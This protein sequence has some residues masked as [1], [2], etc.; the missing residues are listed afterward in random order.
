MIARVFGTRCLMAR[1]LVQRGVRFI[2]LSAV[3]HTTCQLGHGDLEVN[4]NKHAGN[5][6]LPIAALLADLKQ[7]GMLDETLVVWGGSSV[8][9]RQQ[10]TPKGQV[11]TTIPMV[12]PCGWLEAASKEESVTVPPMNLVLVQWRILCMSRICM[13]RCFTNGTGPQPSVVLLQWAGPKTGWG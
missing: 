10:N 2:Q 5:T 7:R 11:E 13:P 1:R 6:D 3:V 4:H 8:D 9:N 12:S